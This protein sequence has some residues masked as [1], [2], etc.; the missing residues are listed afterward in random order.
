MN[1]DT[2]TLLV[3]LPLVGTLLGTVVGGLL[4]YFTSRALE[5][6]R[7]DLSKE[8][9][10]H[11]LRLSRAE[12]AR[13][14][15]HNALMVILDLAGAG[16]RQGELFLK[17][18][19]KKD[20]STEA[21]RSRYLDQLNAATE[22]HNNQSDALARVAVFAP[23]DVN[24]VLGKLTGIVNELAFYMLEHNFTESGVAE[25]AKALSE[26]HHELIIKV[27]EVLATTDFEFRPELFPLPG[28]ESAT[29]ARPKGLRRPSRT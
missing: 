10:D 23:P 17:Y 18:A 21:V 5:H 15:Q 6:Q 7:T 9:E 26:A 1:L 8:L 16:R 22:A 11:K 3:V 13:A 4:S 28:L 25:R 20:W 19:R 12:T 29:M 14:R 27:Y 2:N 24:V